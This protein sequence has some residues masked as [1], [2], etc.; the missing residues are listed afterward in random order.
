[1]TSPAPDPVTLQARN[2]ALMEALRGLLVALDVVRPDAAPD[3]P[4]LI[5][6]ADDFL[7]HRL[8]SESRFMGGVAML[9]QP[10]HLEAGEPVARDD[11]RFYVPLIRWPG[12][13]GLSDIV[14]RVASDAFR[15]LKHAQTFA[16]VLAFAYNSLPGAVQRKPE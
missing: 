9:K 10:A 3:G 16:N 11:G 5:M 13:A 8:M 6:I 14:A 4:T 15:E 12:E 1:M 7:H 2:E